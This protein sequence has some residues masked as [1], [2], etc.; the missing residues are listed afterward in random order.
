MED[1][2]QCS[3]GSEVLTKEKDY[4]KRTCCGL[5]TCTID[6]NGDVICPDGRTCN[7]NN[8]RPWNCGDVIIAQETRPMVKRCDFRESSN[9]S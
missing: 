4:N 5:D 2:K 9:C 8:D 1:D 3:C 6:K 7:T